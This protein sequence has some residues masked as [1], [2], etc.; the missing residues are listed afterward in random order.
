MKN[1]A[2]LLIILSSFLLNA[3]SS[4]EPE[5]R[6]NIV[7][8]MIDD[9]GWKDF[10]EAGSTYYETPNIDKLSREGIRFVKGYS[11]APVCSPSRGALLT[12]RYPARTKFTTVWNQNE[13]EID[14]TAKLHTVAKQG[15]KNGRSKYNTRFED[16]LHYHSLP[17]SETTFADVLSENGYM[18]GYI[19]KWHCGWDENF[20]PDKRG[21]QYAE[22]YR[23]K[24]VRTPH[25][26][27]EAIGNVAGLD[28][29]KP[30]DYVGDKLTDKAVSFISKNANTEKPFM[31]M[32]SHYL[33]HGPLEG[34]NSY[35]EKYEGKPKTDQGRP[36]YAAMVQSVDES[37][38]RVIQAIHD[39]GIDNN[40]V[41]IFTS[42]NGGVTPVTS[43]YPLLG[44]KSFMFEAGTRIPFLVRWKNK[45]KPA[46]DNE[47]RIIQTDIFPTLLDI[48][49]IA[50]KPDLHKDGKSFYPLLVKQGEWSQNPL[51][52]HFP[53][54]THATSPATSLIYDDW[55]LV[56]F[57]NNQDGEQL[58]LFN[59][60]EDPYELID[61]A[62]TEKEILAKMI[63]KMQAYIDDTGCEPPL[64][65]PEFDET[66]PEQLEKVHYYDFAKRQRLEKE[67]ALIDSKQKN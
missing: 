46:V 53:H 31:L 8:I 19:G 49:G 15:E 59:L 28:G 43:S 5:K 16:G 64:N 29:L 32:L 67:Q 12:G 63:S 10:G 3:C 34:K 41:V 58:M 55:K 52:F 36:V 9:M 13:T 42:D 60:K 6:P 45:I 51:F 1:C 56:R 27:T 14:K 40:T 50:P 26:G 65:N 21:F 54:Y 22:G 33:V 11:S 23:I 25:F 44:G 2:L 30:T 47:H 7:L 66:K 57:Y 20:W 35:I 39:A 18:T 38:G 62:S 17:L 37:V 24:P 61:I 4:S 48:A